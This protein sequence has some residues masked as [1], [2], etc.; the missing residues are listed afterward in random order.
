MG[1]GR[2]PGRTE[3][4]DRLS[5]LYFFVD[6]LLFYREA[7]FG[8]RL[9]ATRLVY[10]LQ[11]LKVAA[12]CP[13]QISLALRLQQNDFVVYISAVEIQLQFKQGILSFESL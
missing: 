6:L 10:L 8:L 9:T 3:R 7:K 4:S 13:S 12:M 2:I 11:V 1:C 5:P